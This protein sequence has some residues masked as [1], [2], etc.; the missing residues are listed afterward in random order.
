MA[1][2]LVG[3]HSKIKIHFARSAPL[4]EDAVGDDGREGGLG[5]PS[6]RDKVSGTTGWEED[7]GPAVADPLTMAAGGDRGPLCKGNLLKTKT[8][9][10]C[11]GKYHGKF[12][13]LPLLHPLT[14]IFSQ[15]FYGLP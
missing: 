2:P 3:R 12:L 15:Y 7:A 1:Q 10:F 6:A 14:F 9:H 11:A 4:Q 8:M 5:G 13:F